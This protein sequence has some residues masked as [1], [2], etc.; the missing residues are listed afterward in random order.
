MR[1]LKRI[2]RSKP[3]GTLAG[4]AIAG[5]IR[6]VA[7][8]TRWTYVDRE[9]ADRLNAGAGGFVVAFWHSRLVMGAVLRGETTKRVFMLSS[10]H[11]DA[12]IIVGAAR[13]LGIEFIRGSSA[14]PKKPQKNKGGAG[15]L[16]QM[17]GAVRAGNVVC[18]TPD[19][20]RGPREVAQDGILKLAELAGAPIVPGAWST[21]HALTLDTWDRMLFPLPFGRGWFVGEPP[22][23]PPPPGAGPAEFAAA[24]AAL[25]AALS[26]ATARAD[27]LAGRAAKRAGL[28]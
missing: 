26:R 24:R 12:E 11:P 23:P 5:W 14:D 9:A 20:P 8:T 2:L 19:G 28:E 15:A 25:A 13:R 22:L 27:A 16:M 1:L 3:V 10:N 17:V 4:L 18:I 6:F 7:A 21:T